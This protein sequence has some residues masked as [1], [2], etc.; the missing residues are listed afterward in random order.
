MK[1]IASDLNVVE[2]TL[3]IRFGSFHLIEIFYLC[4][5]GFGCIELKSFSCAVLIGFQGLEMH[6]FREGGTVYEEHGLA[7]SDHSL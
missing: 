7:L 6:Y 3:I 1:Q 5:I 2:L 4:T